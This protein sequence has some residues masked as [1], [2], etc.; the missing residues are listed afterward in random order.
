MPQL[1][2]IRTTAQLAAEAR[3]VRRV[4]EGIALL[5]PNITPLITLMNKMKRRRGVDATKVEWLEDD[6]VARW[7]SNGAA[8]IANT[9]ASTT[10]TVTDGTIFVMGDQFVVPKAKSS[11]ATPPEVVR[12]V[13]RSGDVLTVVRGVGGS[14]VDTIDAGAALRLIGSAH[15]EGGPIGVQKAVAPVT[16]FNYMQIFRTVIDHSKTAVAV[17]AYG[18]PGGERKREHAKKLKEHK[19]FMN[20]A[21]LWGKKSEALTGGP[22]GKPIRT[23]DGLNTVI[24]TNVMDAGGTLTRKNFEQFSR[25]AFRYGSSEKLLVGAPIFKSALNEWGNNFLMVKPEEKV[26][27]VKITRVETG[28]GTWL[29]ANDWML[30]DGVAG[31]EGF[32]HVAFSIDLDQLEYLYLSG[33]GENRDT[34]INEDVVLDG[35]DAYVD[36]ILTECSLKIGMEKFHAKMFNIT[37]W[38]Q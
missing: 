16:K 6:Y 10:I 25:M 36:E 26:Y 3:A 1:A 32:G 22:T 21:F 23:L 35:R 28:H 9:T 13:S 14:T 37:D 4:D 18:A 19:I 11:F 7:A 33:N 31:K 27:G 17:K 15:E 5:E 2:G 30:E 24:E 12:V 20:S 29:I 34:H 38:Q 8:T